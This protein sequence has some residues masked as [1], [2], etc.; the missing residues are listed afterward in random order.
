MV[1]IQSSWPLEASHLP[2]I[3]EDMMTHLFSNT[4]VTIT[5]PRSIQACS[6]NNTFGRNSYSCK[7]DSSNPNVEKAIDSHKKSAALNLT[8]TTANSVRKRRQYFSVVDQVLITDTCN[9][10]KTHKK[11]AQ[12]LGLS[13]KTL[14][15]KPRSAK[16]FT[17][18][19]ATSIAI[20]SGMLGISHSAN[21]ASVFIN[22][23]HYDNNG[24]DIDE[25]LEIAAAAGTNLDGWQLLFYN[26]SDGSVYKTNDLAGLIPNQLNGYGVLSF[27]SSGIQNGP[28]DAFAL[29]DDLGSVMDFISYEGSVTATEGAALGLTSIDV[30]VSEPANTP[31]GMSLQKLGLGVDSED[32]SWVINPASFGSINNGQT[33]SPSPVPLPASLWLFSTALMGV[34][35]RKRMTDAS[36]LK[37][38]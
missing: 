7:T 20:S 30:G 35:A 5:L 33:F 28:A 13:I 16:A 10:I 26:G 32:F 3:K 12:R 15:K 11:Q 34:L 9:P 29:I 24:T 19:I 8:E 37:T 18:P 17:I 36:N 1:I 25:G 4:A 31:L 38:T 6:S 14:T 2:S 21:A 27:S 22:E 23:F